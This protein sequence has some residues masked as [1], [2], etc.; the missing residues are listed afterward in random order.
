MLPICL[1]LGRELFTIRLKIKI[2]RR[3]RITQRFKELGRVNTYA[4]CVGG[5]RVLFNEKRRSRH[6]GARKCRKCKWL[7][8]N[9][10]WLIFSLGRFVAL[11][12]NLVSTSHFA[13]AI[14]KFITIAR[15]ITGEQAKRFQ[16]QKAKHNWHLKTF[17]ARSASSCYVCNQ[18]AF[19][20]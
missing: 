5:E 4:G 14:V 17:T 18:S 15:V 1:R 20:S 8:E 9:S 2:F 6:N 13:S 12:R 19:I 10:S 11:A 7:E 16:C 3:P